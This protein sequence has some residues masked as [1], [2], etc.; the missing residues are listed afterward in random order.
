LWTERWPGDGVLVSGDTEFPCRARGT[1]YWV[2]FPIPQIR[3]TEPPAWLSPL[4]GD[5]PHSSA[6]VGD[7]RGYLLAELAP[8][9]D[10]S[11]MQAPGERLSRQSNR[12]LLVFSRQV[13]DEQTADY[14]LRYFAPQYGSPEDTATGSA[15]RLLAAYAWETDG[16][17]SITAQQLSP[18]RGLLYGKIEGE[19]VWVGGR[20]KT[21]ETPE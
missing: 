18:E 16:R 11:A 19:R 14:H 3:Q 4:L 13:P 8:G 9:S 12:A 21:L 17:S 2:G 6:T 1:T 15:M 5:R 7:E 10:L 20:V